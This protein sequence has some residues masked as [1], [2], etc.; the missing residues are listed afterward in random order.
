MLRQYIDPLHYPSYDD[1]EVLPMTET[2][3]GF[4]DDTTC[5]V[6]IDPDDA[7]FWSVFGY[8]SGAGLEC[9]SD[10]HD[11]D[12]AERFGA[13]VMDMICALRRHSCQVVR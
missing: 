3:S 7:T 12:D 4:G 11:L 5:E 6:A 1:I 9:I 10:H 13:M 2:P 8:R